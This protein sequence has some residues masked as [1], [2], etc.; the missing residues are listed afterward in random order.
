MNSLKT[1]NLLTIDKKKYLSVFSLLDEA[2]LLLST[3]NGEFLDQ[4]IKI[5]KKIVRKTPYFVHA[6]LIMTIAYY[7]KKKYDR[8]YKLGQK[9]LKFIWDPVMIPT[10]EYLY[11]NYENQFHFA[12]AMREIYEE[13]AQGAFV[14]RRQ[15]GALCSME[16]I[17]ELILF[18]TRFIYS[19]TVFLTQNDFQKLLE[20]CG[21][22]T[23]FHVVSE[24]INEYP[25][26]Q[27]HDCVNHIW[28]NSSNSLVVFTEW[29]PF[30]Y[31]KEEAFAGFIV[32]EGDFKGISQFHA[33]LY[34]H[35]KEFRPN[36]KDLELDCVL[37]MPHRDKWLPGR[38][39]KK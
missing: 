9:G 22:D 38:F 10:L 37:L 1:K 12:Q 20:S 11:L 35:V 14:H 24:N 21:L 15:E 39:F 31:F 2:L 6:Y 16:T 29:D 26:E 3:R 34:D 19:Q 4:I 30:S 25:I 28:T 33:L 32:I 18:K 7:R 13:E 27:I 17:I 8:A 23:P 5:G 36:E